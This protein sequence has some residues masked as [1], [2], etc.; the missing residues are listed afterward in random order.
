MIDLYC[1]L[2]EML[3]LN[4]EHILSA[5]NSE[6]HKGFRV[7]KV[8]GNLVGQQH[9]EGASHCEQEKDEDHGVELKSDCDVVDSG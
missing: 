2:L 8:L 7:G 5:I 4:F 6:G 9:N 3:K 1:I